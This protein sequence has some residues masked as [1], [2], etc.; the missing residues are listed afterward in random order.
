MPGTAPGRRFL[1]GGA[2]RDALLGRPVKDRDWVVIGTTPEAMLEAGFVPVGRDFPVFLHPD[3]HEEH[4]LGRTERKSAAG[5]RGFVVHA[6]PDVT[7]EDDLRRRDFTINAIAE[8]EAG[9]LIDPFGGRRDLDARLLRHVSPA[10]AEDPVRILRAARFMARYAELGFRI[11][12]DTLE[13]MR[14]MVEAGEVDHLVPERI[15]QELHTALAEPRPSAMLQTL[16]ACGALQRIL[17]EVDALYGV[18]QRIEFHPEVDA[19]IHTEMVLDQGARL[20]PG[21]ALIGFCGLTHDLG[22]ALTPANVRPKHI[23]HEQTGLA[24]LRALAARLKVPTEYVDQAAIVCREHLNVHRLD[25]LRD[26]TVL[27][28][29]ERC[30]GFRKPERIDRLGLC[31]EADKCGRLGC[32]DTP[33][34]PRDELNRLH[35]AARAVQARDLDLAGLSGEAVGAALRA[36]RLRAIVEARRRSGQ[37]G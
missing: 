4:A 20:A 10:F 21:D 6:A 19:G 2:V 1:V 17:P 32:E 30:D 15:W 28:L 31:C 12:D 27:K 9:A 14:A 11:A 16:R 36:A 24:P 7:L 35:G 33:Y 23:G 34:P 29:I 5:Y 8:D 22:K 26:E 25:E 13:L 18:E 3:T 37:P